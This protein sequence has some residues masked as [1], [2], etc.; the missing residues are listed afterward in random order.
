VSGANTHLTGERLAVQTY[1]RRF[2]TEAV[3]PLNRMLGR[4]R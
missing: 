1:A 4:A 3:L 2:A